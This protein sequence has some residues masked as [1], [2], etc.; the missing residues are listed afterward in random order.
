MDCHND[1]SPPDPPAPGHHVAG[2][3][4]PFNNCTL[5]HGSD[6]DGNI[7][8]SCFTCHD[9]AWSS[10]NEPPAV[11]PGGP[12]TGVA[13][14]PVQFDAS[15]TTDPEGD[16]LTYLWIFGDGS[17]PQFPSQI[18]T[19]THTY[20]AAG[21]YTAQLTV[22]DTV[23]DPV[24]TQVLVEI[25]GQE[26]NLPPIVDPG[27]PYTGVAG[28]PVQFDASGT[29]DPDGDTLTYLWIF[30][31]G[32]PPQF[33]SQIPT[34]THT[35][36][37]AGTYTAQLTVTDT[38]NDPVQT[39]VLVEISGQGN[40]PPVSDPDGPYTGISGSPVFLDGSGSVDPDG[41]ISSYD[42]DF[43]DGV[44]GSGATPAHT[45][46]AAGTY[47]ITLTVTDDEGATNTATST[48]TIT[49][50]IDT[51]QD[52]VPDAED[53]CPD[54]PNGVN[55]GTCGTG[56]GDA[57]APCTSDSQC[58]GTCTSPGYCSMDQEDADEDN[59]GDV[60]DDY[61][62]HLNEP[63]FPTC[64]DGYYL[65]SNY[66]DMLLATTAPKSHTYSFHL[67]CNADLIVV[68]FAKEGHPENKNCTPFVG[69]ESRCNQHQDYES[70][71]VDLDGAIFGNYTDYVGAPDVENAWF[72]A[73]QWTTIASDGDHNLTFTH[74]ADGTT[75]IQSVDYM[76]SV[77]A[78]CIDC[79]DGDFDGECDPDDNCPTIPNGPTRGSCFNYNTNEVWG[80]CLDQ[81]N[82]QENS[83]EWWKWCDFFQSDMD[84]NGIG[85]VC[86]PTP[87]P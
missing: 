4:D 62:P 19:T 77:C 10:G 63:V 23:N 82:C 75:G 5:C 64:P 41:T 35:Y 38:V 13:G 31:D 2:R 79:N 49:N 55:S 66:E 24:Q 7:G 56:S 48:A 26:P 60:C 59:I 61:Y 40:E 15:A 52:G 27:G 71:E 53:N 20:S 57:G 78:K 43:G 8:P 70:F 6:L 37:A 34:T 85:D 74:S 16:T 36:S 47:T 32:S 54:K 86:E 68:G 72:N 58:T 81:G 29:T 39:Q 28:Q 67:D 51:D 84:K 76:V 21:T 17:P 45:Y 65:I 50:L 69:S 44:T 80:T 9:Q 14:Q 1:F 25:S 11:D 12:Y 87:A 33:P 3:E 83:D 73:G 42:W 46:S 30:G 18:P 22:T